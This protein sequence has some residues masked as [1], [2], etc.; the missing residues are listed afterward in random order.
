MYDPD[1]VLQ[2]VR[3]RYDNKWRTWVSGRPTD[4]FAF[5]L[6]APS[7]NTVAREAHA[8]RTW[9]G[10]WRKWA[11]GHPGISLRERSVKTTIGQQQIYTHLDIPSVDAL[12]GLAVE[13][14]THWRKANERYPK[15]RALGAVKS[16]INP[17][18]K[19]I[20]DLDAYDFELLLHAAK[21][22]IDNPRSGL[23]L[24]QVPV[25][26]MHTKWLAKH[27]GLV[28]ALVP[29]PDQV[30]E[31]MRFTDEDLEPQDLDQLGLKP[32]PSH[33]DVI[34]TDPHDRARLYGLRHLR[35]P[36]DEIAALPLS[37]TKALVVENKE[38]ALPIPDA[39][40]LVVIH[41]LG[42]FLDVLPALPWLANAEVWYWG[43]LDRAGFTLLSR[44]RSR[45]PS[46][47]SLLMDRRT[48]QT[49]Q[50]LTVDDTT[51]RVDAPDST[52]TPSEQSTL[53]ALSSSTPPRRLEQE[54]LPWP[55]AA[56]SLTS[57]GIAESRTQSA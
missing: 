30:T 15:L 56:T 25:I 7:A 8:V 36:L 47:R 53:A 24:R 32:L 5:P 21:W 39:D 12:A 18:L 17:H 33:V 41:S 26:G 20:V 51:T 46:I 54:R 35:A 48:L 50:D 28:L 27:R 13:T 1:A 45:I 6:G 40:G 38:T 43:D 10:V 37:P 16:R 55:Y 4:G 23:T 9:L 14:R 29:A 57:A 2:T 42:N 19:Q 22:F 31:H 49:H 44:A 3:T 34:L 11:A 52:L